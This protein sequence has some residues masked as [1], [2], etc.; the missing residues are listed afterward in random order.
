MDF[1]NKIKTLGGTKNEFEKLLTADQIYPD[2]LHTKDAHYRAMVLIGE[3]GVWSE[4][5]PTMDA[6]KK[7][8]VVD[9]KGEK[10]PSSP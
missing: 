1:R 5:L 6:M 7:T 4:I 10:S 9:K 3:L 8:E 2:L